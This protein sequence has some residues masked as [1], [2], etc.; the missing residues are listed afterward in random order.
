MRAIVGGGT[1]GWGD[2]K[3][4]KGSGIGSELLFIYKTAYCKTEKKSFSARYGA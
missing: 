2:E 4:L 3:G 1:T